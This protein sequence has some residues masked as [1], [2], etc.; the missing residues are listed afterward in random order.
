MEIVF[1][2]GTSFAQY[3]IESTTRRIEGVGG[4]LNSFWA[5][6]SLRMSFCSGG[7]ARELPHRP[8]ASA[9]TAGMNSARVW[10]LAGKLLVALGQM[11]RRVERLERNSGDG[12]GLDPVVTHGRRLEVLLPHLL[13][14]ARS[15]FQLTPIPLSRPVQDLLGS[16]N[17]RRSL[18][19]SVG[20]RGVLGQRL[21]HAAAGD[22]SRHLDGLVLQSFPSQL[23]RPAARL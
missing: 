18:Q 2:F 9:V 4:K 20:Q 13:G 3:S 7:E 10:E 8:H 12:R 19:Q 22:F 16:S 23:I 15:N 17:R 14:V 5:M 21:P 1:H 11:L 6:N